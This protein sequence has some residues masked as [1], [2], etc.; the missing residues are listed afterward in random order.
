MTI[1]ILFWLLVG[2]FFQLV[3]SRKHSYPLH[4]DTIFLIQRDTPTLLPNTSSCAWC[5]VRS[6]KLKLPGLE[7]RK[8]YC[9]AKQGYW[10]ACALKPQTPWW[11]SGRSFLKAKFGIR[12]AGCVTFLLLAGGEV[13]GQCSRDLV[14]RL[15]LPSSTWVGAL[16]PAEELKGIVMYNLLGGTRT[17]PQGCTIV[18]WLF[19]LCFCIP[20]LPWLATVW[21]CPLELREGQGVWMKPICYKQETGM[22]K[23]F[24][25]GRD[26]QG[27]AWFQLLPS[28]DWLIGKI[29]KS[30]VVKKKVCSLGLL[31]LTWSKSIW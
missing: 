21:I 25:S 12:A 14:F 4:E 26:P 10:V 22:W 28:V 11:F 6:N 20:S 13:T 5:T 15:K 2:L 24:V 18:S 7:Q 23:G 3:F 16:V 27:P 31:D 1:Y 8:V 17:L 19:L 9:R 29:T 30:N